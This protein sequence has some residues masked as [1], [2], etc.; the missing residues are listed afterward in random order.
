[1]SSSVFKFPLARLLLAVLALL[2]ALGCAGK[3]DDDGFQLVVQRVEEGEGLPDDPADG[4]AD[5]Y[6]TPSRTAIALTRVVLIGS[7]ETEDRTLLDRAPQDAE[8]IRLDEDTIDELIEVEDPV[9]FASGCPCTYDQV[10][11]EI[12]WVEYTIEMF[13]GDNPQE[14]RIRLYTANF[15]DDEDLDGIEVE[16]GDVLIED[17]GAFYWIDASDGEFVL[18]IPPTEDDENRPELRL[19]V[20][21]ARFPEN[22]YTD[23]VTI[24][25]DEE[26]ELERKPKGTVDIVLSIDLQDVIFFDNVNAGE[27]E[28]NGF[29]RSPD[30]DLNLNDI[31]S[32]YYPDFPRVS[33]DAIG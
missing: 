12:A 27:D 4:Y 8:V 16:P 31:D 19:T 13:H 33:V 14:H 2:G 15:T 28:D 20:P 5:A 9:E 10:Q 26:L 22:S 21:A 23:P 1:M 7:G 25:L 18:A 32:R 6:Q 11:F 17:N 30:G 24:D 3:E 29:D